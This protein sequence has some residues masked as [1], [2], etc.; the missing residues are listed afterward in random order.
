MTRLLPGA[1]L[2]WL[3]RDEVLILETQRHWMRWPVAGD[4]ERHERICN[5]AVCGSAVDP[6]VASIAEG[7]GASWVERVRRLNSEGTGLALAVTAKDAPEE[8]IG[9]VSALVQPDTALLLSA[10]MVPEARKQGRGK[11]ALKGLVSAVRL[12]DR[13]RRL[14]SLAGCDSGGPKCLIE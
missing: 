13:P 8:A 2:P 11:E 10:A 7:R 6:A 1:R 9:F 14:V 12:V 4:A 3:F 5:A